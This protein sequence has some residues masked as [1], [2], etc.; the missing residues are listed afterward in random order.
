[1]NKEDIKQLQMLE[2]SLHALAMQKQQ[3]QAQLIEVESALS[4]LDKTDV[5]YKIVG[6]IMVA[7]KKQDLK[8]DLESKKE[9]FSKRVELIDKQEE[10][11]R[12]QTKNLQKELMKSM[13]E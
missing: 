5:A 4:E 2:Q 1:M 6:N 10:K 11:L 7:V 8:K 13:K 3:F 12:E 9:L